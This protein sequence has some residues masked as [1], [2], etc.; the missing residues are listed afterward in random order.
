MF[1]ANAWYVAALSHELG[2]RPV[3]RWI[4]GKPLAMYRTASGR[5]VILA[6]RC[7]HCG[8]PLSAGE[9]SGKTLACGRLRANESH[10]GKIIGRRR[11]AARSLNLSG[12]I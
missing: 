7:P 11:A 3:Q 10:D 12:L 5:A 4:R 2:A 1:L 8:A 6:E 9:I